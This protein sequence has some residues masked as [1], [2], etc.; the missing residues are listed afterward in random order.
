MADEHN[1]EALEIVTKRKLERRKKALREK[2]ERLKKDASV[3]REGSVPPRENHSPNEVL[4]INDTQ[5]IQTVSIDQT[6]DR[7]DNSENRPTC[8]RESESHLAHSER[9]RRRETSCRN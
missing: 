5:D 4:Q 6:A 2:I 1:V 3:R 9:L 8:S 7:H